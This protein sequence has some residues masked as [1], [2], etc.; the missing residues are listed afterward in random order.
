MTQRNLPAEQADLFTHLDG[1]APGS[2]G[3]VFCAHVIEHMPPDALARLAGAAFRVLRP[4]GVLLLE[5]PNPACLAIFATYFY[6]DPTHVRPVPAEFVS[7]LLQETGFQQ[8]EVSGLHPAQEDF[9]GL[10]PLPDAFRQ[11][12]FGDLDYAVFAR[13]P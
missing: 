2:I 11:Q 1:Q 6:L 10:K 4:G 5:T 8:V 9:A 13:K 3:G 12:F 7:Y